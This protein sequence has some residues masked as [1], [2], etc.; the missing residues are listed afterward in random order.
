MSDPAQPRLLPPDA[1]PSGEVTLRGV[2]RAVV[3]QAAD[4]GFTVVRLLG[5]DGHESIVVGNLGAI[6]PGEQVRVTG[7]WEE[8]KSH[9]RQLRAVI[10]VPELPST[11]E[12]IQKLLGSGFVDGIGPEMSR[13]IVAAFGSATLDVIADHPERLREV[14]GIGPERARRIQETFRARRAESE[15]RAFLQALGLGPALQHRVIKRYGDE[16]VR[17]VQEDPYR[18]AAEVSG[19]GFK[20]A[21]QI[22]RQLGI[23]ED[24]LRRAT[25]AVLHLVAEAGESG[26]TALPPVALQ[27]RAI[28]LGIPAAR[29]GEAVEALSAQKRVVLDRELLYHPNLREAEGALA[30]RLARALEQRVERI[31]PAVMA[32][33]EVA[34]ALSALHPTQQQAVR[35]LLDSAVLV[36]TGGPGTGKTTTIKAIVALA[37]SAGLEIALAAPTGRAARRMTEATREPART[38]HRMLE[39]NPR[40]GRFSRDAHAPLG[41]DVVL[42]DETSM[43][44]VVIASKLV[45][46]VKPGA[47]MVFVGDADQLPSVGPGTV[48]AD[49][50]ATPW[51][52]AVRLTEVFRQAS[53]S[54]IVRGAH[55]VLR[56]ELPTSSPTRAPGITAPPAGELFLVRADDA[57]R[58][59]ELLVETVA[60]RIPRSFGL[61][62]VRDVQVLVPTHKGPL[63]AAALNA[64]LQR[65]LNP[66]ARATPP[67]P[68]G[69]RFLPGDKVMQLRNDYD[70]EVWNGDIG[71]VV[72]VDKEAVVVL[73]DGREVVFTGEARDALALAYAATV[74]KAQG[75]EYDAVV[76]GLHTSHF[77]LLER[78]LIYTAITRARRLA[79]IVGSERALKLAIGNARTAERYGALRERLKASREGQRAGTGS[80]RP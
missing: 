2:V 19:I 20:T 73:I 75:S 74:H 47:R 35:T 4:R 11:P 64:A 38:I 72:R 52:P 25:G 30:A 23:L 50:L 53:A 68:H 77:M 41:A 9:G 80:D 14:E 71:T 31:D 69:P 57:E 3:F 76:I 54:A 28:E 33:P 44:D 55:A 22:G 59:A 78:A 34:A 51:I 7:R 46:A 65:E 62:P 66:A 43:L 27:S 16:T 42:V 67:G 37:K 40:L 21:D 36:L 13:R 79:V 39:W 70:L 61:D 32:K 48:L 60:R 15:A 29:V 6:A 24:D 5:L 17:R 56:G 10:V 18:L 8:H 63:G 45:A 49:L 26:H 1:P 58:A 12:G